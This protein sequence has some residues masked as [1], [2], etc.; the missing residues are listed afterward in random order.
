MTS[1][2]PGTTRPYRQP[3]LTPKQRAA[4][5]ARARA[6]RR[7]RS[8]IAPGDSPDPFSFEIVELRDE[9]LTSA[10][11]MARDLAEQLAIE[12]LPHASW[13]SD[14]VTYLAFVMAA[15]PAGYELDHAKVRHGR[16]AEQL[17]VRADILLGHVSDGQSLQALCPFCNGKSEAM[18]VGGDY[19]LK[20]LIGRCDSPVA[21]R[22]LIVCFGHCEPDGKASGYRFGNHPAWDLQDE[23]AWFADRIIAS[24]AAASNTCA[25]CHDPFPR[26]TRRGRP[27][28][29]CS[30]A[31]RL[32]GSAA[33]KA[34]R[35]QAP[36]AV[37]A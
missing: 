32:A 19:T 7:E 3:Q 4:A 37:A 35:R 28:L 23:G 2:L 33:S 30:D 11:H 18:P 5:D 12:P 27:S 9:I 20:I 25:W 6:E 29:Y 16:L 8:N 1:I 21:G 22:T 17:V 15:L 36:Q 10:D 24:E 14:P 31:H 26:P 13:G 34:R